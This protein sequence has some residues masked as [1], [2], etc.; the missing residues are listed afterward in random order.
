MTVELRLETDEPN[1]PANLL[2]NPVGQDPHSPLD[3]RLP[4]MVLARDLRF[5]SDELERLAELLVAAE[6]SK[7][8]DVRRA[9]APVWRF[10]PK[11]RLGLLERTLEKIDRRGLGDDLTLC[12][13]RNR[14]RFRQIAGKVA[15]G[16][17][18]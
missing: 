10:E 12:G 4:E 11:C 1:L 16:R 14:G 7:K 3:D 5:D 2:M 9:A 13:A 15:Q 8:D 18:Q 17:R 6:R